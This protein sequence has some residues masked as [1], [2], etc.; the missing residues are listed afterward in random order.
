MSK[1]ELEKGLL[2]E[3]LKILQNNFLAGYVLRGYR[4]MVG[5]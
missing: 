2:V 5:D 3:A 1:T 4:R